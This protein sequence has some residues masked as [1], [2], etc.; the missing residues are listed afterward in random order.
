MRRRGT[1]CGPGCN[2]LYPGDCGTEDIKINGRWFGEFDFGI[3]KMIPLPT[4][5]RF[6]ISLDVFNALAAKD[7]PN[8]LNPGS[9]ANIFRITSTQ[10]AARTAQIQLRVTW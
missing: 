10:S 3:R 5:A 7:F 6:E 1:S 9:G 2:W 4:K 8:T